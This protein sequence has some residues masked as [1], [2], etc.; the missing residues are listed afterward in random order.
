MILAGR[1]DYFD[2]SEMRPIPNNLNNITDVEKGEHKC[3]DHKDV[4]AQCLLGQR[5]PIE[6]AMDMEA[7]PSVAEQW[8]TISALFTAKSIYNQADL[9]QAFLDMRCLRGGDVQEYLTSLR[10]KRHELKA[11]NIGV[12][13]IEYKRTILKGL[14]D[15]LAAHAAQTLS[16]LRLAVKYTGKPIDMLDVID[17]VCEEADHVKTCR[18]LKDQSLGQ[19]KGKKGAQTDEALAATTFEH[20]NNSNFANRRKKGKC[21]HCGKE[22]HWIWECHTKKREEATAQS[23]QAAQASLSSKPKNKP[24]GSANTVTID[25]DDSDD[26]GFWAVKEEEVHM[27]FVEPD[28]LMDDSDSDDEDED[29]HAEL[30]VSDDRLDWPDIEGEEWY[31]K[32]TAAAV[33]TPA[34]AI[35]A[36]C[37]K[38]YDSGASQ[39]ISPYKA[40]FISYT[41]LSPPLYLNAAN[42]HKFP[43]IRM[44]TLIVKTPVNGRESVLYLYDALYAPSVGY[45]LVSLGALDKEGFMSHI[46]D[47]HLWLTSPSG[48]LIA[49]VAHNASCLYKYERSPEYA[50]A[51]ELL[52]VMELHHCLGHISV[53][54]TRKLVEIR[55]IKGIKLDPDVP[56]SD[57][58]ACIFAHATRIPVPKPRISVPALSFG[59]EIHTDVWGPARIATVKKK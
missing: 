36:P 39:H 46:G 4:I 43:A 18:A 27:H 57:C 56:E 20:S 16:M 28:S 53:A 17:L 33:I 47:G 37:A 32:D 2:G 50:H 5:L 10:M 26:R 13:D 8:T 21:N 12:T 44:G 6:T 58:E 42:Q 30:G 11:A 1:W 55:A 14:P 52:S 51:V 24:V 45:T 15:V 19:G 7:F 25:E 3:W 34:E 54:S 9:H 49:N 23:G 48:E 40:D 31:F 22:G 38:L 35:T 41:T 29:F 59:D